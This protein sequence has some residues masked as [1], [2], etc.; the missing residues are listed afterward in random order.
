MER[1]SIKRTGNDVV[2]EK[3]SKPPAKRFR[4]SKKVLPTTSSAVSLPLDAL[5]LVMEFLSPRQLYNLA[6]S[7][8]I[9]MNAVNTKLIVKAALIHGGHAKHT[10]DELHELMTNNAIHI[11]SPLRL[12]RLTNGKRCEF[13]FRN[14]VNFVRPGLGVFACWDCITMRGLTKPWKLT[15]ARYRDNKSEYDAVLHHP[16]VAGNRYGDKVYMWATPRRLKNGERIGPLA[17]FSTVDHLRVWIRN[18]G[19]VETYMKE[20]LH[21]ASA[22]SY[23]EFNYVYD[24]TMIRANEVAKEREQKKAAAKQR[25]KDNRLAKLE[26]MVM[27]LAKLLDEPFQKIALK[28]RKIDNAYGKGPHKFL[29]FRFKVDLVDELMKPYVVSPSKLRKKNLE[30]IAKTLNSKFS[31]INRENFLEL[32]F[33]SEN[34]PFE[35]ALKAHFRPL[36]PDM[37][38]LFKMAHMRSRFWDYLERRYYITTLAYLVSWDLTCLLERETKEETRLADTIWFHS[39]KNEKTLFDPNCSSKHKAGV[40][41]GRGASDYERYY[42][43]DALRRAFLTTKSTYDSARRGL[44]AYRAWLHDKFPDQE[45]EC[46]IALF[47][48]CGSS[49]KVPLL[50]AEDFE[51]LHSKRQVWNPNAREDEMV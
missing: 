18:G 42:D 19:A 15:W 41:D 16:R 34:D 44:N 26:K 1:L 22:D 20:M 23:Q 28:Y 6:F 40:Y 38:S 13:C 21:A 10:V 31:L 9:L 51:N 14:Q 29:S 43:S 11:P 8:K 24:E 30:D 5:A 3:D 17:T 35:A 33:L 45:R 37:K 36:L 47:C 4:S 2:A 32:A 49:L 25:T 46:S 12:L 7:C 39:L 50:I 27:D 48:A